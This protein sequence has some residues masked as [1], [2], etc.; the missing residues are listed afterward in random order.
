MLELYLNELLPFLPL[1]AGAVC[2]LA[3][4]FKKSPTAYLKQAGQ[5]TEGIIYAVGTTAP[6]TDTS[7]VMDKITVRFVTREGKWITGDIKQ[8]FA[9]LYTNQYKLGEKV[10][11]YY[12]P[13]HPSSFFV[14]TK[15]SEE[16]WRMLFLLIG[17]GLCAVGLI[18]LI[19]S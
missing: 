3:A 16:R 19:A 11:V 1:A 13:Q 10:E 6:G 4:V 17:L 5:R 12:D 2:I 18:M 8:E 15:Q 14:K 7:Y 9:S